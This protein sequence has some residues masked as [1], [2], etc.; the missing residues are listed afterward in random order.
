MPVPP[1]LGDYTLSSRPVT[2]WIPAVMEHNREQNRY[3]EALGDDAVPAMRAI[4]SNTG[5]FAGAFG[6]RI[7]TYDT[8]TPACALSLV[9]TAAE[10]DRLKEPAIDA[11]PLDRVWALARAAR[12]ALGPDVPIC[13][14]DIQ[15]PFDIAAL[16]WKK[17]S[18]FT[19]MYDAPEAVQSLVAKCHGLLKKF[20]LAFKTEFKECNLVHCPVYWAPP[21]LGCS[22]S[23][24][25]A[26]S[27]SV[28][29]FEQF[30]LPTLVDLSRTFGGLFMHCCATADHQYGNFLKIP[31][32]RGLNRVFQA[33]GPK[34]AI[35]AFS[36]RTVLMMAW[37]SEDTVRDMI[38][39]ARSDTRFLFNFTGLPLD[40][41]KA[42]HERLR[43]LCSVR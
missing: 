10:A 7:H 42:V 6:C 5:V 31:N 27:M 3:L 4:H 24:D 13:T 43:P 26:G 37:I 1:E 32:L 2:E 22:L 15:S 14:P 17:E 41:A 18:M 20:L 16:I 30:C 40:E 8:E 9:E 28:D 23:E 34:P 35:D 11:P 25:E 12:K 39:M 21:E 19:A 38:R 29:M 33:P 36:G